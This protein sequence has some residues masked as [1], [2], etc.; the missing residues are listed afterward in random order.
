[1]HSG[2]RR[3]SG[4]DREDAILFDARPF[5]SY[6][7]GCLW[8]KKGHNPGANSLPWRTLMT[9]NKARLMKSDEELQQPVSKFN[10]T[11]D[12]TLVINPRFLDSEKK[13]ESI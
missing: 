9:G 5:E 3:R 7:E 6:K 1:M 11:S 2:P 13:N 8:I 12:K 10:I 4:A